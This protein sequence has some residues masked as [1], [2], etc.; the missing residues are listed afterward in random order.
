MVICLVSAGWDEKARFDMSTEGRPQDTLGINDEETTEGDTLFLDQDAVIFRDFHVTVRKKWQPE[1]GTK[2][3]LLT[4]LVGPRKV[5]VLR[6][7]GYSKDLGVELLELGE[8]VVEGKNFRWAD[9]GKIP[10]RHK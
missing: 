2:T 1:I 8:S 3:T 7:G 9:E 4:R 6:V 10:G 5:G